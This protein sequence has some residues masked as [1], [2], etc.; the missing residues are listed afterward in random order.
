MAPEQALAE[1]SKID[2]QTDLW[3][4]GA[5]LFHLATGRLVHE[6]ETAQETIVLS[7][8]RPAPSLEVLLPDAPPAV[9]MAI[10][11]ALAFEKQAR[12]PDA[13]AMR[14]AIREASLAAFGGV[15][16]LP[17]LPPPTAPVTAHSAGLRSRR[18]PPDHNLAELT[19]TAARRAVCGGRGD[20]HG[21]RGLHRP[22][23]G[24]E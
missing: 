19:P 2:A 6:G 22:A 8:T 17:P 23:S 15:A 12:W 24:R 16:S 9:V 3:G 11:R 14:T 13:A 18:L 5:T 4:V 10:D 1:S 20:R 7:A 21:P